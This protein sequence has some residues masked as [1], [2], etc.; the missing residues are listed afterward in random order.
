[1]AHVDGRGLPITTRSGEAAALYRDGVDLLLSAWPGVVAT[2]RRAVQADAGFALA[3]AALARAHAVRAEPQDA[4]RHIARAA[5]LVRASGTERER[6]HVEALSLAIGGH[7]A[8]ALDR[9]LTHLDTWPRQSSSSACRSAPSGF[10]LFPA[11]LTTTRPASTSASGT[12]R[13]FRTRTGGS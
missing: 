3:H 7:G 11:W 2:L 5:E 8:L 12:P 10:S 6:S 9:V 4:R 1:M 13:S